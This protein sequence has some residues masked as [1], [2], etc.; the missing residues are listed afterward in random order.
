PDIAFS[1]RPIQIR[2]PHQFPVLEHQLRVKLG[3]EST[4][5]E[6]DGDVVLLD[7]GDAVGVDLAGGDQLEDGPRAARRPGPRGGAGRQVEVPAV[8]PSSSEPRSIATWCSP[9]S[10]RPI[11][12]RSTASSK[13][14]HPGSPNASSSISDTSC[15]QAVPS[16]STSNARTGNTHGAYPPRT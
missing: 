16:K 9:A 11:S 3:I 15:R 13:R 1:A 10:R 8:L 7:F 14:S 5:S 12:P 4:A 2:P 6:R